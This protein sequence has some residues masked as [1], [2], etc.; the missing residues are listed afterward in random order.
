MI[1]YF[2]KVVFSVHYD[3]CPPLSAFFIIKQFGQ[4][5]NQNKYQMLIKFI[6]EEFTPD[7]QEVPPTDD[8][9][10]NKRRS[11]IRTLLRVEK[12]KPERHLQDLR[13]EKYE[14]QLNNADA[15]IIT[16]FTASYENVTCHNLIELW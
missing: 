11:E 13:S 4:I 16:Y 12:F 3:K 7:A 2:F 15:N 9:K 6:G 10:W 5:T 14:I 8:W 1:T